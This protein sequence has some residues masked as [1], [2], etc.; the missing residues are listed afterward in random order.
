MDYN[1]FRGC[2]CDEVCK[3]FNDCCPDYNSTCFFNST[4]SPPST[5]ST[6]A[7][8]FT[9]TTPS[10][11][12]QY[13]ST[14]TSPSTSTQY[15]SMSTTPSTSTQYTSTSTSPSTSPRYTSTVQPKDVLTILTNLE[16]E[17]LAEES[18][19]EEERQAA[20]RQVFSDL[21][22]SLAVNDT[23]IYSYEVTRIQPLSPC[24]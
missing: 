12:T 2:F 24:D 20:L 5:N 13:T 1:C 19:T 11:S 9:S 22:K 18:S 21:M 7:S 4:T 17:V 14:S 6:T 16:V 15:T 8:Q 10:T 3:H 23:D